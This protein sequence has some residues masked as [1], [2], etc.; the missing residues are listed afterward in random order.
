GFVSPLL[1][2]YMHHFVA[3]G[4]DHITGRSEKEIALNCECGLFSRLAGFGMSEIISAFSGS[5]AYRD[6]LHV[7][8]RVVRVDDV[9]CEHKLGL[10]TS[11]WAAAEKGLIVKHRQRRLRFL[12]IGWTRRREAAHATTEIGESAF[13]F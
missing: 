5:N 6:Q 8:G 12:A 11:D 10:L 4:R 9:R 1:L 2:F 7:V 13:L 3:D